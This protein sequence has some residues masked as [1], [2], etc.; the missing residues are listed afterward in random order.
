MM[1]IS[2]IKST[3]KRLKHPSNFTLAK[4]KRLVPLLLDGRNA[5]VMLILRAMGGNGLLSC[6]IPEIPSVPKIIHELEKK[7]IQIAHVKVRLK[8]IPSR[9]RY[10]LE[11]VVKSV[12]EVPYV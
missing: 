6:Q 7:G 3:R 1:T 12:D 11:T 9:V 5:I 10:Y 8:G 4:G 2:P